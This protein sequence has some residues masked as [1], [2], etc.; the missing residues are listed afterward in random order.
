MGLRA[1]VRGYMF[2]AD[3][4][5]HI[6]KPRNDDQS[7]LERLN[8]QSRKGAQSSQLG[9]GSLLVESFMQSFFLF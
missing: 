5:I 8:I 4:R 1:D 2:K 6:I 7:S 3:T 9:M